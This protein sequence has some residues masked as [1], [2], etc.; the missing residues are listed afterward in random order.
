MINWFQSQRRLVRILFASFIIVMSFLCITTLYHHISLRNERVPVPGA[1]LYAS[2]DYSFHINEE[3]EKSNSSLQL[4]FSAGSG[5]VS[6]YA[7]MYLL[8]NHLANDY[9]T[10]LYERPGYGF[11]PA[12]EESR[13]IHTLTSEM[14][15]VLLATDGEEKSY[16]FIVHSMAALEAFRYAQVH[17]DEVA[18]II[19]LDGVNPEFAQNM[20]RL[21]S[22]AFHLLRFARETGILRVLST[23]DAIEQTFTPSEELPIEV[24][25]INTQMTISQLWNDAMLEERR[26]L[27]ASGETIVEEGYLGDLPLLILTATETDMEGWQESQEELL[28]WSSNSQQVLIEGANHDLHHTH[29]EEVLDEIEHFLS[30][31]DE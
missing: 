18:G 1:L 10:F 16:V 24:K 23:F 29:R 3:G 15:K 28:N 27:N 30:E 13:D 12:I 17:S 7:D 20:D 6:P 2:E 22:P 21:I 14:E 19:L 25:E 8:Q 9:Y 11:S 4:I 31:I 5:T 26:E